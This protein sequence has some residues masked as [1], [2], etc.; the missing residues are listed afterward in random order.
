MKNIV[1]IEDFSLQSKMI[2]LTNRVD[3][4]RR[5]A[6]STVKQAGYARNDQEN[7]I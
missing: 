3:G 5:Q 1:A 6:E 4:R 7:N 2:W